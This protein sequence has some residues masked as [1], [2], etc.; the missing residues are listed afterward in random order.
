MG[1]A[2]EI[3]KWSDQAMAS[4]NQ[5]NREACL[6]LARSVIMDT[7]VKTGRA[8]ANWQAGL[9]QAPDDVLEQAD[10]SGEATV[11]KV[12]KVLANLK[13]GDSFVLVNN[14]PYSQELEDGSSKQAPNGMLKRN[15]A[16]W[17]SLVKSA[18]QG[19]GS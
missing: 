1:F 15:A 16:N 4:I 2:Q 14:L 11:A 18:A 10:P 9:N 13:P 17:P 7:P 19:G 3:K 5:A 12:Q 8:R 6:Q